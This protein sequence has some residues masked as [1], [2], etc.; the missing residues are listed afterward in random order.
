MSQQLANVVYMHPIKT[1]IGIVAPCYAATFAYE[2]FNPATANMMLSHRL[3]HTR[4]YGQMIA[5]ATTVGVMTFVQSMDKGGGIYR[6]QHGVVKRG[7]N[8]EGLR[9]WYSRSASDLENE[10]KCIA[11]EYEAHGHRVGDADLLLPLVYAPLL[12]LLWIGLRSRMP[13]HRLTQLMMGITGVAFAHGVYIMVGDSSM[14][15]SN[16]T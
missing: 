9:H 6:L 14:R 8:A 13:T 10:E 12:P 11:E 2:S 1:T 15:M 16:T 5:I 7:E 4:V 3:I